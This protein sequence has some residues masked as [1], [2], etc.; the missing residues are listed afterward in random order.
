MKRIESLDYLRGLM[1]VAVMAY[2][3][4]LWATGGV[5]DVGLLARLGIYAVPVFYILSGLSL[6][7]VYNDRL[8]SWS[9]N[10][11]FVVKRVFRIFPLFWLVVTLVLIKNWV[12]GSGVD[13][14]AY[15]IFLNYTLLFGFVDPSAYLSVGAW[16]IGNEM[17]FY[18]FFPFV[19]ALSSL[20]KN[21]FPLAVAVGFLIGLYFAFFVIND[22]E[23]LSDQWGWYVN[24]FNQLYFFLAGMAIG[25]WGN[26]FL[27]LRRGVGYFLIVLTAVVFWLYP[28]VPADGGALIALMSGKERVVFSLLSIL[29]VWL[30]YV[31]NPEFRS[32]LA[33]MLAFLGRGC[34]SIY[35][36]HPVVAMA[37]VP[38]LLAGG[39]YK[40]NA[41]LVCFGVT[42]LVSG[43]TF[44]FVE[45]P[46]MDAGKR[47]SERLRSR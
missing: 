30:V 26:G 37:F 13:A 44:R 16:S 28:V 39:F 34:Y 17:V 2:H 9:Q 33:R 10:V 45:R 20:F 40:T 1:A 6:T 46:M 38:L 47:V 42:L 29:F 27:K 36:M 23:G 41:Y 22:W 35:L 4:K 43:L 21:F 25:R 24:P 3:Y 5:D 12:S 15:K 8:Y 31:V 18:V 19:F 14:S 32:V 11:A 7:L